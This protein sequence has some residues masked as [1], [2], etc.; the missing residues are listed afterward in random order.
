MSDAVEDFDAL[1]AQHGKCFRLEV[2]GAA[3]LFRHMTTDEASAVAQRIEACPAISLNTAIDACEACCVGG[4]ALF[5]T[6]SDEYP[7]V[8]SVDGGLCETL[9]RAASEAVAETTRQA[10]KTWRESARNLGSMA[11]SLLAFQSYRGGPPSADA[12]AGALHWAEHLDYQK[13]LFKLHLN[14]MK[15]MGKRK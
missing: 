2:G 3:M 14:F 7:L 9:L 5:L 13:N 10:L 1:R 15:A 4:K 11:G 8:F 12:L 6:A